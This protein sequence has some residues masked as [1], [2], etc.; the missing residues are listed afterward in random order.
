MVAVQCGEDPREQ[1][2]RLSCRSTSPALAV[3]VGPQQDPAGAQILLQICIFCRFFAYLHLQVPGY[4]YTAQEQCRFFYHGKEGADKA[5]PENDP[6]ICENL[7]CKQGDEE[8]NTG[9]PLEGTACGGQG[10]QWCRGGEC[11]EVQ[12]SHWSLWRSGPCSSACTRRGTGARELSRTC[13]TLPGYEE[14]S[15]PEAPDF[16]VALC[17]DTALCGSRTVYGGRRTRAQLATL[18]CEQ[19][20]E[21][22]ETLRKEDNI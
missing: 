4:F 11:V 2:T 18:L 15:C 20:A 1:E 7:K 13:L 14:T 19:Q 9:P 22:I 17:E 10:T 8:V 21:V 3:P 5:N 16:D 6:F 12:G